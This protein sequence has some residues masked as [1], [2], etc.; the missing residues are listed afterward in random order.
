MRSSILSF[1]SLFRS[2]RYM[3]HST[4]SFLCSFATAAMYSF[5]RIMVSRLIEFAIAV[6]WLYNPIPA[7]AMPA[8][9]R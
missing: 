4:Y 5:Q 9:R 3:R 2:E 6:L 7:A 1:I 8:P